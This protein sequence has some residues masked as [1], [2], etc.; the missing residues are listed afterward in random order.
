M[1]ERKSVV[2]LERIERMIVVIRGQKVM[3]DSD[4]ADL[5]LEVPDW[6]LKVIHGCPNTL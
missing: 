3:L 1:S 5:Y 4:L 2:P 6:H